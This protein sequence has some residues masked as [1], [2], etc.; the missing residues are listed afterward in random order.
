MNL[1]ILLLDIFPKKIKTTKSKEKKIQCFV[2]LMIKCAIPEDQLNEE[3]KNE[4]ERIK[5]KEKMVNRE[6]LMCKK[7]NHYMKA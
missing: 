1:H 7:M 3:S 2:K 5:G 6:D 4:I